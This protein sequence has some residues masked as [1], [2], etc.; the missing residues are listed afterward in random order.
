MCSRIRDYESLSERL[1]LRSAIYVRPLTSQQLAQ[2]LERAG[3]SLSTLKI[4]LQNNAELRAF[5]SSPLILSVMSLTYQ[6]CSTE[7]L[8]QTGTFEDQR[9][10]LFDTYIERMFMRRGTTQQYSKEQMLQWLT[11]LAQ[12]M[13]QE[14][15][16]VFLIERMQPSWLSSFRQKCSYQLGVVLIVSLIVGLAL[17]LNDWLWGLLPQGLVSTQAEKKI[18]ILFDLFLTHFDSITRITIS[19]IAGLVIGLRQTIK[20]I[21]TLEWSGARAWNGMIHGLIKWSIFGLSS[22]TY[23]GLIAGFIGGS[24][25]YLSL[26]SSLGLNSEELVKWSRVGQITGTLSGL[27]AGVTAGLIARPGVWLTSWRSIRLSS[28]LSVALISGLIVV[29]GLSFSEDLLSALAAGLSV[30]IIAGLCKGLGDRLVFRLLNALIFSLIV[31]LIV[32]L[33]SGLSTWLIGGVLF[34]WKLGI[35]LLVWIKLWL[36]SGLGLGFTGGLVT[37]LIGRLRE[38]TRP[39]ET[40]QGAGE[41]RNWLILRLRKG[42]IVGV[43]VAL[44]LGLILSLFIGLDRILI[45]TS[46]LLLTVR[47]GGGLLSA[48]SFS[49][50]IGLVGTL[51]GSVL[52]AVWGALIGALSGGLTGPDLERRTAPNQGIRQSAFNVGVFALIGGLTLGPIWGLIFNLLPSVLITELAPT[53]LD[54]L[55]YGLRNILFLGLLCSLVP[56]AACLQHFTLRFILWCNEYAPWNY[57]RFLDHAVDRHFMQKVGGGYIFVHRMLMEHFAQMELEQERR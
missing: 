54:W 55:R 6:G 26:D 16:T 9:K 13:V 4:V 46:I 33:G 32:G 7:A 20:P 44:I 49:G 38:K 8:T 28:R 57:V 19:L 23:V 18:F 2:F 1:K 31:G 40:L 48:L 50:L 43:I 27:I 34:N 10:H 25:F 37:G 5:A 14:S 15:Q 45:V 29:I 52:F 47:L 42:L 24:I 17:G 51:A 35:G 39:A 41:V 56:G 3:E 53:A 12:R 21:E 36:T 30:G 22:L 11:W